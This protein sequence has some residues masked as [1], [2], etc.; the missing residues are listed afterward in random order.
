LALGSFAVILVTYCRT[1]AARKNRRELFF[2]TLGAAAPDRFAVWF[3][4]IYS[5]IFW[6][7]KIDSQRGKKIH[8][9]KPG[10][11]VRDQIKGIATLQNPE[12]AALRARK[13]PSKIWE[14]SQSSSRYWLSW[15]GGYQMVFISTA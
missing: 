12:I 6:R 2:A 1:G 5:L 13:I 9:L 15:C 14:Q 8:S 10:S 3:Y 11:P 4:A 7:A